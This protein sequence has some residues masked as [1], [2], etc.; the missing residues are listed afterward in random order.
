MVRLVVLNYNGG[1]E[2]Q[3]C[4][5]SLF[6][7]D[8]PADRL[9]VVVVDNASADGSAD[10][11]V[12]AHPS[13]RLIRNPVNTGFSANNLAMEDLDGV[14]FVGLVNPDAWVDRGWLTHLV[15]AFDG[16]PRVGAAC[17][18]MLL[19]ERFV[20]LRVD[21]GSPATLVDITV[22]G[23]SRIDV[24]QRA[25]RLLQ[26]GPTR[27]ADGAVRIEPGEIVV[28]VPRL[29]S[30]PIVALVTPE[31]VS[32]TSSPPFDLV[33]NTGVVV[34]PDL[35][36]ADRGLGTRSERVDAPSDVEAWTGGGVLLRS[37]YL[38][39]VGG[40]DDVFFL[41]YEDVDLS[42]RGARRGWSY[43]YVPEAV[44][45]HHHS[46]SST[47]GS[48]LFRFHN[49]RSRLLMIARNFPASI[50]AKAFGRFVVSTLGYVRAD[51]IHPLSKRRR[52]DA[53]VVWTRIRALTS[54]VVALPRATRDH[55]RRRSLP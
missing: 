16:R 27:D 40:F 9:E 44:M 13:V 26:T 7:L 32:Y 18:Q 8:W 3:E 21:V 34:L 20:S 39:D 19:A 4:V 38:G 10:R 42:L 11:V 54:A 12:A 46:S 33:N 5:D 48:D 37:E 49:E 53:R 30:D 25:W 41:Y 22:D 28:P 43:R 6:A 2:V 17:P 51:I 45:W 29:A 35:Y 55:R 36:A 1:D 31:P 23:V 15:G 24:A 14:D 47:E 52:P 50:T